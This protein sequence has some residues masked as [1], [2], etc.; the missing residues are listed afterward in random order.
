MKSLRAWLFLAATTL[1][2]LGCGSDN[3]VASKIE[4]E[5]C[6][7]ADENSP[8]CLPDLLRITS[9]VADSLWATPV[10]SLAVKFN[11]GSIPASLALTLNGQ[12]VLQHAALDAKG[13]TIAG[14]AIE[15][16]LQNGDNTFEASN[17][18][19]AEKVVFIYDRDAPRIIVT[20]ANNA[21]TGSNRLV[22]G[23]T[24]KVTGV[25][26]DVAP[27]DNLSI[28]NIDATLNGHQFSVDIPYT[29]LYQ[30]SATD[31]SGQT[32]TISFA[33][34]QHLFDPAIALQLN[35]SIFRLI[36]PLIN[37][38]LENFDA[39]TLIEP[40]TRAAL[41]K[42]EVALTRL[43]LDKGGEPTIDMHFVPMP[44][45]STTQQMVVE[46]SVTLPKIGIGM[47]L[48][49]AAAQYPQLDLDIDLTDVNITLQLTASSNG[50]NQLKLGLTSA[51]PF[52]LSFRNMTSNRFDV[53]CT[54]THCTSLT[55]IANQLFDNASFRTALQTLLNKALAPSLNTALAKLDLPNVP[56]NIP[57]DTDSDGIRD[58][59]LSVD[60]APS[61]LTTDAH[62]DS[63]LEIAARMFVA[64]DFLPTSYQGA[65]GSVYVD[66]AA[67]PAF[68]ATSA[69]A[70]SANA[71]SANNREFDLGVALPANFL[72]QALFALY[73]SGVMNTIAMR[74]KPADLG[75]MGSLLRA[76]GVDASADM[77]MR[78]IPGS[79]PYITLKHDPL[80]AEP[81]GGETTAAIVLH[82][83]NTIIYMD[84]K[85]A[86]EADFSAMIGM[87]ADISAQLEL[88]VDG[89]NFIELG[90]Q[91]LI[92]M[93]VISILPTG[94]A[95]PDSAVAGTLTPALIESH[96]GAAV[97]ALL[98]L[99]ALPELLK[100]TTEISVTMSESSHFPL[101]L[102]YE[103]GLI[104]RDIHVDSS[105]AY[106]M[107]QLD[108]LNET[109]THNTTEPLTARIDIDKR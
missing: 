24:V 102:P 63:Y 58:T 101:H 84:V 106:M 36:T 79:V 70:T 28:N 55:S 3:Q 46:I 29:D 98:K 76:V 15:A 73:Q 93:D 83:D 81:S 21:I 6:K 109:E 85:K 10:L 23:D 52:N 72:N 104:V 87:V 99:E 16:L 105:D 50:A 25:V 26:R 27:I 17:G 32:G 49:K 95:A 107:M 78:L 7:G 19:E 66:T 54:Q 8:A 13:A 61:L 77:R 2:M 14:S 100:K 34:P 47:Q 88:G 11:E 9:P 67:V 5:P 94:L 18:D 53:A 86:G 38:A 71:A 89:N 60:V 45:L 42:A 96:I 33:A 57:L 41:G 92:A 30:L 39:S 37:E 62:G 35:N 51:A 65:L 74:M 56:M 44:L 20:T 22:P 43:D 68:A 80:N 97:G 48:Y 59:Q 31:A 90:V 4:N 12:D 64:N 108:L 69:N 75:S 103:M 82:M 40:G 91:N 1:A